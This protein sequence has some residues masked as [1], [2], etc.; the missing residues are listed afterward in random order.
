M[1]LSLKAATLLAVT[2]VDKA[3]IAAL[4]MLIGLF[5]PKF[6]VYTFWYPANSRTARIA[7]PAIIPLPS[8]AGLIKTSDAPHLPTVSW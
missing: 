8:G 6:F 3:L 4:T 2:C 1:F 5:E 7:P